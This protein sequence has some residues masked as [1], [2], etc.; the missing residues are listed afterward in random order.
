MSLLTTIKGGPVQLSGNPIEILVSGASIPAGA[1]N[2][3]IMLRTISQDGNLYGAP[4]KDAKAPDSSGEALFDISALVDQPQKKQVQYP[5]SGVYVNYSD[6]AYNIQ[7]QSGEYYVDA[8]NLPVENWGAISEVFQI[9]KGGSPPRQLSLW[10]SAA[11]DFYQYYLVTK[12]FLTMRPSDDIV[13]PDQPVKLYFMPI[14]DFICDFSVVGYYDDGTNIEFTSPVNLLADSL[15][16]FN[17]NPKYLG[18]DLEPTG[19]K[20]FRFAVSLKQGGVSVSDVRTFYYD[21]NYCERPYFMLFANSIGGVDDVY[22]SGFGKDK[23]S[24]SSDILSIPY[25]ASNTVFDPTLIPTNKKASNYWIINTGP[26]TPAQMLH[27]RDLFIAKQIWF[28]YPSLNVS[29]YHVIPINIIDFDDIIVDRINNIQ[30]VDIQFQE[31]HESP[32]SFENRTY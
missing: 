9:L 29:F 16:E 11:T 2:Y 21:L 3:K 7:V 23:F 6:L 22:L 25:H 28:L 15:T 14:E 17:C 19:K 20:M 12:R 27:L 32:F 4:F 1:S 31:A 8:A 30:E 5:L 10:N 18:L 13:H 24:V 26:K